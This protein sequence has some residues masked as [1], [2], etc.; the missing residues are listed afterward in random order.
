[1]VFAALIMALT[2]QAPHPGRIELA[3]FEKWRLDGDHQLDQHIDS[4]GLGVEEAS[5]DKPTG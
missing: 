1:M 5:I 4:Y 3:Y 2:L